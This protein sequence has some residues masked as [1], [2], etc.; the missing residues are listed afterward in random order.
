MK[1]C[2]VGQG[3]GRDRDGLGGWVGWGKEK[4]GLG[5]EG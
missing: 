4:V 5:W 1:A 3:R 2:Q